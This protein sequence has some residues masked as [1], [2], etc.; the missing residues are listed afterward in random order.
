MNA[1]NLRYIFNP[2]V[3][4]EVRYDQAPSLYYGII[5]EYN[6]MLKEIGHSLWLS[7]IN[8]VCDILIEISKLST[9]YQG[10]AIRC[11]YAML[12]H[13]PLIDINN[14]KESINQFTNYIKKKYSVLEEEE[15][16]VFS[17]IID[18]S[19]VISHREV[20][21]LATS[22]CYSLINSLRYIM[23]DD[24]LAKKNIPQ[25]YNN[26]DHPIYQF[27]DV[28]AGKLGDGMD[29]QENKGLISLNEMG[30]LLHQLKDVY[31]K[32]AKLQIIQTLSILAE[33]KSYQTITIRQ[34]ELD[35]VL[36][37]LKALSSETYRQMM[38][39]DE[40]ISKMCYKIM[41]IIDPKINE[42]E[43]VESFKAP[44]NLFSYSYSRI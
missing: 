36:N 1:S 3:F 19:M 37:Q 23:A 22:L 41:K 17:N 12:K 13:A 33:R 24:I 35:G 15:K 9:E 7:P 43:T 8:Y 4:Y 42:S 25:F 14:K 38:K 39:E 26:I 27:Y 2:D 18:G 10:N 40:I 34:D 44:R 30:S 31:M 20:K 29:Y 28:V 5:R 32:A 16:E 21:D 6:S 11:Y